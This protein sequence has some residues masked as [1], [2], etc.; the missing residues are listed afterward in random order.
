VFAIS[1]LT[2]GVKLAGVF[3][4]LSFVTRA[5]PVR[6]TKPVD[7]RL[8][9]PVHGT[10]HPKMNPLADLGRVEPSLIVHQASLT[11][12]ISKAQ[13]DA[14]D[15]LLEDQRDPNSPNYHNWITPDDF[16]QR[17]G[18]DLRDVEQ[19]SA[20][21]QN[22]GLTIDKVSHGRV[23]IQFSGPAERI[24][25]A[26]HT[27]LHYYQ[28]DGEKHFANSTDI[29]VPEA[30]AD[31]VN[32]AR[33][34]NDFLPKRLHT[35]KRIQVKPEFT[36]GGNHSLAPDDLATIYDIAAL[37]S[38]GIDGT[39]QKL[40]IAGQ[41]QINLTDIP[42]FRSYFHLSTNDPQI[43][44]YG[45]NPGIRSGDY[46]EAM[47]DLEWS[48]AVARNATIIY[49]YSND[50]FT[51]VMDAIDDNLAPVI[52]VSYGACEQ[53]APV[54]QSVA[55]QGNAEGIT[56][57][58]ASGD[59]GAAGCGSG[60]VASVIL[61]ADIP[62]VTAVGGT[63][64]NDETGGPWWGPTNSLGGGSALS[65][66]PEK[67]WSL[68][69]GGASAYYAKPIWQTG[70]GVPADGARDV[71]DVALS[72]STYD[73][74]MVYSGGWWDVGGTSASS[75]SFA[76]IV[77]LLN[78]YLV[79]K[80][81]QVKAGV[82]NINP[83][84]YQL[85]KTTPSAFHDITAGNNVADTETGSFGYQAGPGYDQVTGL[86]SVDAYNLVT[87]WKGQ[88]PASHTTTTY[89]TAAPAT[90]PSNGSV[91]ITVVV[92]GGTVLSPPTGTITLA[93]GNH[94]LATASLIP[95]GAT[96]LASFVVKASSLAMGPNTISAAFAGTGAFTSSLA[97]VS[98]MVTQ[99]VPATISAQAFPASIVPSAS[100]EL[101][102]TVRPP[103]GSAAPNGTVTLMDGA[104]TL[105]TAH[106]TS[107]GTSSIAVFM[108]PG[109]KLTT[110]T[111]TIK[112]QY[113]SSGG[114]AQTTVTVTLLL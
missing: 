45:Y 108:L 40:V 9:I 22:H 101:L 47:L 78:H 95:N 34:I 7:D 13:Q 60:Y 114:M 93:L 6:V 89:L 53:M 32:G 25:S 19:L 14:L 94:T 50:V 26:F 88:Q 36:S 100:T 46:L 71:P 103:P 8:V 27:E 83:A 69:G 61:P 57:M 35:A 21:L 10:T 67:G 2:R 75:P 105:G 63:E 51:S 28:V 98:V 66:I 29:S 1:K 24:E 96:G 106:L 90:V 74:Y 55:Q 37:Y 12:G 59:G 33:G 111:N 97:L 62:E 4:L 64:L 30:F 15:R 17:F 41:T 44:L 49:V 16:G 80:G 77:T 43:V 85:A 99:S 18:P 76:G 20:W 84:L 23:W 54:F 65:Y 110:G 104:T 5:T 113:R 38:A 112:A 58:N 82:G 42:A 107:Y 72:A 79:S 87:N 102:I 31:L 68:S 3:L 81:Y 73:P 48:G 70:P 11:L 92:N 86:G 91:Q 39:G 109:S 52:S 56:W